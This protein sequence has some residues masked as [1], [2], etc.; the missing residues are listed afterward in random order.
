MVT[1]S[2]AKWP[3]FLKE[4]GEYTKEKRNESLQKE[5][6]VKKKKKKKGERVYILFDMRRNLC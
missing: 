3:L 5:Q 2:T 6:L 1:D 4:D